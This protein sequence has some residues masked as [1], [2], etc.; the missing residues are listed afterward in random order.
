MHEIQDEDR[1]PVVNARRRRLREVPPVDAVAMLQETRVAVTELL[2]RNRKNPEIE[3]R[4]CGWYE[5]LVKRL[6]DHD[7]TVLLIEALGNPIKDAADQ[8]TG[9]DWPATP[10]QNA[11]SG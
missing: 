2:L 8:A 5:G 7:N 3:Q 6:R 10:G 1:D 4:V 9:F 11:L